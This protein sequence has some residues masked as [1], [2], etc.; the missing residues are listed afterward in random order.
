MNSKKAKKLRKMIFKDKN[1]RELRMYKI[2]KETGQ[3][4]ADEL[5]QIYQKMKKEI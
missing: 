2:N 3:I 1:Y 5:R 4:T